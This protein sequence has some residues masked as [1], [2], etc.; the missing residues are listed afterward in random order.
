MTLPAVWW[1]L[2]TG[3][4]RGTRAKGAAM[5]SRHLIRAIATDVVI[6]VPLL[7]AAFVPFG[8]PL[9]RPADG[10]AAVPLLLAAVIVLPFRRR[11]PVQTVVAC[12]VIACAGP[13]LGLDTPAFVLPVAVAMFSVALATD[14]RT[15]VLL[16]VCA[17]V[18]LPL[19]SLVNGPS[20]T[21]YPG[22]VLSA[23]AVQLAAIVAFAAAAGDA[24]RARRATLA[25]YAE[26]AQRAEQ[27]REAE[28][29]QRV[30]EDRLAIARDLH[31]LVAHQIAVINLNAGVASRAV[32]E[33]PDDA[34]QSL[35]IISDAARSVITEIGD[36]LA[37]L[38]S[39]GDHP[40]TVAAPVGPQ[41]LD[42]LIDLFQQQGLRIEQH[43]IGD[44]TLVPAEVGSIA[45]RVVQEGLTN[46][47]K[48]GI[49][50]TVRLR[51]RT[52]AHAIA[53]DLENRTDARAGAVTPGHGLTG[54]RERVAS[55]GGRVDAAIGPDGRFRL[56]AVL[57]VAGDE[58]SPAL[59][60]SRATS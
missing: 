22:A 37:L 4:V 45:Y 19:V 26:R 1:M 39:P 48:H 56:A 36:L 28:A 59:A 8:G 13:L 11:W 41:R 50:G 20:V 40:G 47:H 9:A 52:D 3:A 17:A 27:S 35:R 38:R 42:A 53:I 57:P 43:R 51:L 49:D 29:R 55:V 24:T 54:M 58:T 32:R 33:R 60:G 14:R 7:G 25:A 12:V 30:A 6:A 5:R 23:R 2:D 34:E 21:E 18:V 46:A 44:V 16:A 15:T 10:L 31:D